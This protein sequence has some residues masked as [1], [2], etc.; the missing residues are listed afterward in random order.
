MY[1]LLTDPLIRF[2]HTIN[3][4]VRA[5][6]P[7]VYAALMADEVDAFPALRPH[8]RHAWHA[9]LVQLGVIAMQKAGLTEPPM[10]ANEW[11]RIIRALTK[12]E[13]PD[14][15]PWR[16]VVDD[17][18]KPAFMQPP[19]GSK[20][21]AAE[22]TVEVPT[23]DF[24]DS[25]DTAKNHALK[26]AVM[27]DAEADDWMFAL[28]TEQTTDA[29]MLK[30]PAISRISGK[31]SRL[32]FSLAPHPVREGSHARRDIISLLSG[33][34]LVGEEYPTHSSGYS[35]LWTIVWDDQPECRLKLDQLHKL[36]IEICRRRRLH[37]GPDGT[38]SAKR[39]EGKNT[40]ILGSTTSDGKAALKG[41]TGDPWIPVDMKRE[42][43]LTLPKAIGFT[44]RQIADC[45]NLAGRNAG[46]WKIPLLCQATAAEKES[47]Q[48]M[49]L[50]ARGISP[51][52]GQNKTGGYS[53]RIIPFRHMTY[54][55]FG[56]RSGPDQLGDIARERIEQVGKV[57]DALRH[58]IAI[59]LANGESGNIKSD[60]WSLATPRSSKLD[61]IVDAR[62]FED[63]QNE[64]EVDDPE[65]RERIRNK[66]LLG[67]E[68]GAGILNHARSILFQAMNSLP[69]PSIHQYRASAEAERLF[70][71]RVRQSL[72]FLFTDEDK[73][74]EQ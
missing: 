2:N 61:E 5:S 28:I 57:K 66:W 49:A 73:E 69:C 48:T 8:Q 40:R 10:D 52:E 39:A 53:E 13:F 9:F 74:N 22:F 34:D 16:L 33:W 50:V 29:H 32:A 71:S 31:G 47:R 58:A 55:V 27:Q 4:T 43:A 30:N 54:R 26:R 60:D 70:D 24:L 63:L 12:D 11:R 46:N 51:G 42:K 15:E 41:R 36:Y 72:S 56:R 14:D 1:N 38:I 44:Y 7:E 19:A 17:I 62:F 64:F 37:V 6:L 18:T 45:L 68:E 65:E 20:E 3:G 21:R 23:P 25:L 35:L 67:D 59:F